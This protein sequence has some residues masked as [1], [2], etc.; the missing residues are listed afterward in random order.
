MTTAIEE[1]DKV[2]KAKELGIKGAHLMKPETLEARIKEAE[3]NTEVN[4]EVTIE[5][6]KDE[7]RKVAP[8]MSVA[9]LNGNDR[10]KFLEDLE[11]ENPEY[12]YFYQSAATSAKDI[13]TK[14]LEKT[15]H[16][17]KNNIV[18]RTSKEGYV[19]WKGDK[20]RH[21]RKVMDSIDCDGRSI[22]SLQ[23]RPKSGV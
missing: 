13:E 21:Q 4:S 1:T 16:T 17:W 15:A 22:K 3:G 8:R 12:K 20:R 2:A 5:K 10:R 19:E 6:P 11:K 18:C 23:E 14:G 9:G 7:E